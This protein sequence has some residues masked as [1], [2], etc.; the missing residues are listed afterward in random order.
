MKIVCLTL[1]RMPDARSMNRVEWGNSPRL[2]I[3]RG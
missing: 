2:M 3:Q 1:L